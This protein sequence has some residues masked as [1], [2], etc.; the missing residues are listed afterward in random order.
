MSC[1]AASARSAGLDPGAVDPA[2][3]S[4]LSI[5][6]LSDRAGLGAR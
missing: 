3:L 5:T 6:V 1:A 2:I 4:R